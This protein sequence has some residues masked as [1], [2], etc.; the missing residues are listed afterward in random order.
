M[1]FRIYA[2]ILMFRAIYW[3]IILNAT[4][5]TRF[6]F[7]SSVI[8]LA[9]NF[10]GNIISCYTIGF[11]GP[12]VSSL[13][14]TA[15]MALIQLGFSCRII[16]IQFNKILPW[17]TISGYVAETAVLACIFSIV[18]YGVIDGVDR[19]VSIVISIIL[20]TVWAILY[21]WI[22]RKDLVTNWRKLNSITCE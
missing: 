13:L 20:G 15:I 22:N 17:R 9:L 4:G 7:Y 19:S 12:A 6:V 3:G 1:V 16:H 2:F 21:V 11:V 8:T 14:V 10:V 5:Q 18:R